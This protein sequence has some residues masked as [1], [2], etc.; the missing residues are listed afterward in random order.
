MPEEGGKKSTKCSIFH[1]LAPRAILPSALFEVPYTAGFT[2]NGLDAAPLHPALSAQQ[3]SS[4]DIC[5]HFCLISSP[6]RSKPISLQWGVLFSPA[7]S[8]C[9][10]KGGRASVLFMSSL[11][12]SVSGSPLLYH[13]FMALPLSGTLSR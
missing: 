9:Y 7:L 3:E 10:I 1:H 12:L 2:G 13:I 11:S 8:L 4:F 5:A 6:C